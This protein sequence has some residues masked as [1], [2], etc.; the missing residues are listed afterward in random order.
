MSIGRDGMN[1]MKHFLKNMRINV[2]TQY[3]ASVRS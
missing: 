3:G 2:M 1:G